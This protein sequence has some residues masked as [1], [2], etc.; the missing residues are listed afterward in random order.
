M[1]QTRC[2]VSLAPAL[3]QPSIVSYHWSPLQVGVINAPQDIVSAKLAIDPD[4]WS[5]AMIVSSFCMAGFVAAQLSAGVVDRFGRRAFL[6]ALNVLFIAS[7]ACAI[8]SSYLSDPKVAYALLLV[9]RI[10]SGAGS[11]AAT[12]GVPMY[13]GEIAPSDAKGSYGA[14]NQFQIVVWIL[15]AQLIGLGMATESL[16]GWYFGISAFLG[17][18]GLFQAPF[19]LE[20]PRWLVSKGKT[21]E[22]R[23]VLVALRGYSDED[24]AQEV[25]DIEE[26]AQAGAKSTSAPSVFQLMSSPLYRMPLLVCVLLQLTQQFS[27]INAVF[28]Y[29]TSFF[30][31]AGVSNPT[32]GT[33]LAG[34]INLISTAAAIP[35][36][37]KAGRRP[38]LL[39]AIVGMIA[40]SVALTVAL[41]EKDSHP[42]AASE[43]GSFSVACVMLY[44]CFFEV[45]LGA[46]PWSIGAELFPEEPRA[47]AMS[48]AA[49]ANWVANTLVGLFFPYMQK[50]LG[51]YSFM[52]F[53]GWLSGALL[54]TLVYVP[55]TKGK[56]PTELLRW[57]RGGYSAQNDVD[58]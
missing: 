47:T 19:L 24:A 1:A 20:S 7:G 9:S 34:A 36:I 5:W 38:L 27:G 57:F 51:N 41:V 21:E 55:E 14:L 37:E 15:I 52:P 39:T 54:F 50:G 42:E 3:L 28:F 32:V 33:V 31:A 53:V 22:A 30:K 45:G 49:A 6:N 16:W 23:T 10:L 35:L 29:S 13:L 12:V 56:S 18:V 26:E 4:G 8:A 2:A 17:A 25:A 58:A 43:L 46:I 44:I 40:F 48:L 11:G